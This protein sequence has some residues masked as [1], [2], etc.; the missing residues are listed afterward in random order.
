MSILM[1]LGVE[2]ANESWNRHGSG[3]YEFNGLDQTVY[4]FL[5]QSIVEQ[6]KLLLD[7]SRTNPKCSNNEITKNITQFNIEPSQ[8]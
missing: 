4:P 1:K 2:S 6:L 5:D 7:F 3:V 8:L